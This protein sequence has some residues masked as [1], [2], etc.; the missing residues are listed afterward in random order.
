MVHLHTVDEAGGMSKMRPVDG[1]SIP[2]GGTV[3]LAPKGLHLMLMGLDKP[4]VAGERFPLKLHFEKSGDLSVDV[5][6]RP[7][8]APDPAPAEH[9]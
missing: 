7:A 4:L 8:T 2:A 1:V 9:H 5:Q 6:V 3:Q